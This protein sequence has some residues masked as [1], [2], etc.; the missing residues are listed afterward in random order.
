MYGYFVNTHYFCRL[1]TIAAR[2]L[3]GG[4]SPGWLSDVVA[5]AINVATQ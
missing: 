2:L 3:T 4:I 1:I 5:V